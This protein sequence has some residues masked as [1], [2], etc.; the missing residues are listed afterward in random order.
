MSQEAQGVQEDDLDRDGSC[1]KD[2]EVDVHAREV[3]HF[4]DLAVQKADGRRNQGLEGQRVFFR[5]VP[6]VE[7]PKGVAHLA[8]YQGDD[9]HFAGEEDVVEG[10]YL[11]ASGIVDLPKFQGASLARGHKD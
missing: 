11:E 4:H 2:Q 6:V 3:A 5:Q 7:Y 9:C 8:P 10:A 1:R